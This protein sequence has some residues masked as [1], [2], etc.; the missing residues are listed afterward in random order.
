MIDVISPINIAYERTQ[1][2]L[3]PI[4]PER[5][6][7]IAFGAFLMLPL[8]G[9]VNFS[10]NS[11]NQSN[12]PA[13]LFVLIVISIIAFIA[14][15]FSIFLMWLNA[16]G[17]FVFLDN[18]FREKPSISEP[19][20]KYSPQAN[21]LFL[22]NLGVGAALL[23]CF[24]LA[25]VPVVIIAAILPSAFILYAFY[26]FILFVAALPFYAIWISFYLFG[27]AIMYKQG[28]PPWAAF[29]ITTGFVIKDPLGILLYILAMFGMLIIYCMALIICVICTLC[30][31][32]C[33][34]M[35]P[36]VGHLIVLPVTVFFR[37]YSLEILAP[38]GAEYDLWNRG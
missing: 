37:C 38:F 33:L 9:G 5:W 23:F 14:L 8:F 25:M 28:I 16:Y 21:L 12:E 10:G 3:F 7:T 32:G 22:F 19:W 2:I 17:Q 31:L 29:R 24:I 35:I 15:V 1:R 18:L 27:P 20:V 36:F 4:N 11:H 13:S 30:T 6:V 34:L 26:G